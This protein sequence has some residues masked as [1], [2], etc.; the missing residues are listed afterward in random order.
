MKLLLAATVLFAAAYAQADTCLEMIDGSSVKG[1]IVSISQ[2]E[3][4]ITVDSKERTIARNDVAQITLC[5]ARNLMA[6]A[7]TAVVLSSCGDILSA[8]GLTASQSAIEFTNEMCGQTQLPIGNAWGCFLDS[9]QFSPRQ[10]QD[11]C[12]DFWPAKTSE[13]VLVAMSKPK[14]KDKEPTPGSA[15]GALKAIDAK[16]VTFH[17]DDQDNQADRANVLALRCAASD[18]KYPA[19]A[20][21]VIAKDGTTVSFSSLAVTKGT[22]EIE[23]LALGK[24]SFPLTSVA[25]MRFVS[26]KVVGLCELK[27]SKVQETPYAGPLLFKYCVNTSV[28]GKPMT[29]GGKTY[30]AGLGLH[31]QCELTYDLDGKFTKFVTTAGI[32]DAVPRTIG[33]AVLTITADGKQL[34]EAIHLTGK[35]EHPA[36]IKLDVAKV[37][38]L[39]IRVDFGQDKHGAGDDVDL[40]NARLIK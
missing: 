32:D 25:A 16:T 20:G 12:K 15:G 2:A 31:S 23:S 38:T 35:D 13:D 10:L 6:K 29:L 37:K 17:V 4:K 8:T 26:D 28:S 33:D 9:P 1:E 19:A 3:V 30:A 34:G 5:D 14:E 36:E 18:T 39:T 11:K 7:N 27:P 22:V 21:Q 40:A 24:K